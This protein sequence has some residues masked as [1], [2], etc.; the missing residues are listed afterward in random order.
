[1]VVVISSGVPVKN[2]EKLEV[3]PESLPE[4]TNEIPEIPAQVPENN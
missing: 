3:F 1:M 4:T 2:W